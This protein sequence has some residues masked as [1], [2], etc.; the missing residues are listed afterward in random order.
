MKK[1]I[2]MMLAAVMLLFCAAGLAEETGVSAETVFLRIRENVTAQVYADPQGGQAAAALESGRFCVLI[3][4]TS[5]IWLHVLYLNDQKKGETGYIH[6]DDAEPVNQ[7]E[8]EALMEDP[9]KINE[10]LD[11]IDALLEY[12]SA[13]AAPAPAAEKETD[14]NAAPAESG[15]EKLYQNAVTS[16]RQV[17]GTDLQGTLDTA[18]KAAGEA[19]EAGRKVL[20]S[21]AKDAGEML[22]KAGNTVREGLSSA[23]DTAKGLLDMAGET[24]RKEINEKLPGAK[25]K[26]EEIRDQAADA[27]GTLAGTLAGKAS[28]AADAISGTVSDAVK[29]IRDGSAKEQLDDLMKNVQDAVSAV[30]EQA[31]EALNSVDLDGIRNNV[32][33]LVST[34]QGEGLQQGVQAVTDLLQGLLF[35]GQE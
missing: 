15:F 1:G 2:A 29:A 4:E 13:E 16:L 7:E 6:A 5:D 19:A 8:L 30:K 31:G 24:V 10:I 25:E 3:D 26:L 34:F 12:G 35:G 11:L 18:G 23:A 22:G 33:S 32:D 20:E 28:E 27:A 14:A 21:A 9:E 17:F